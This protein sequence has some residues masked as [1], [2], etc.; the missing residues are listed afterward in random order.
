MASSLIVA[1]V[2][3][4]GYLGY[5]VAIIRGAHP[6]GGDLR[7]AAV[8]A[9]A[10]V[11]LAVG[12]VVTYLIVPQPSSSRTARRRS[13]WSAALGFFAAVPIA[14]LVLVALTQIVEPFLV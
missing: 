14:Y 11:V 2:L 9:Y 4:L 8:A 13:G 3:G 5:D 1:L 10:A 7:A 6:P 12:S